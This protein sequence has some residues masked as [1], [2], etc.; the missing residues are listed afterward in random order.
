MLYFFCITLIT[1]SNTTEKPEE[2][3]WV[4]WIQ[5]SECE[6]KQLLLTNC[7][8]ENISLFIILSVQCASKTM[9]V[10]TAEKQTWINCSPLN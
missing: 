1:A 3:S 2:W 4:S 9:N 7:T 5:S 6:L 10:L 8:K